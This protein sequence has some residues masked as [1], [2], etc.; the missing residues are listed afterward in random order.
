MASQLKKVVDSHFL[1]T[2]AIGYASPKGKTA[3]SNGR[4]SSKVLGS[5]CSA[6]AYFGHDEDDANGGNPR[7]ENVLTKDCEKTHFARR[8]MGRQPRDLHDV[9]FVGNHLFFEAC[10]AAVIVVYK[11]VRMKS[12]VVRNRSS[13]TLRAISEKN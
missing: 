5:Y 2:L 6:V 11:C 7:E 10:V 4:N 9:V 12:C 3:A 13:K 1:K 8:G